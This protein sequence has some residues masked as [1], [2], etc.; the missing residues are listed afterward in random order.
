LSKTIRISAGLEEVLKSDVLSRR[1]QSRRPGRRCRRET[2]ASLILLDVMLPGKSGYDICRSSR[3]KVATP[4][5]M[6]TAKVRDR[7]G[8]GPTSVRT[9]TH[10]RSACANC[11]RASTPPPRTDQ[12][13]QLG[14]E[15]C[16]F[17]D[18]FPTI[19]P[20]TFNS[21]GQARR[22]LTAKELRLLQF[23]CPPGRV[24]SRDRLLNEVWYN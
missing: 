15:R 14:G 20:K 8:V 18:R 7:Q 24:L 6:L 4:I 3:K 11:W 12:P 1:L 17:S 19:D 16:A 21:S 9:I 10:N 23:L 5:L 2:S 22:E 13:L